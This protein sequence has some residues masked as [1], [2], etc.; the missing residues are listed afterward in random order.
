MILQVVRDWA[1]RESRKAEAAARPGRDGAAEAGRPQRGGLTQRLQ[2]P[3][4]KE[5]TLKL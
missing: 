3:L 5:Y 2:Y 1:R 4:I